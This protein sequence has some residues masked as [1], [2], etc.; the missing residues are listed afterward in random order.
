MSGSFLNVMESFLLGRSQFVTNFKC[1]VWYITYE[2]WCST[3]YRAWSLAFSGVCEWHIKNIKSSIARFADD[4]VLSYS[5]KCPEN[6]HSVLSSDL[7]TL[8]SWADLWSI[9]FNVYKVQFLTISSNVSHHPLL[10]LAN[11]LL[12]EVDSHKQLG[13]IFHRSSSWHTH[14]ISQGYH[15]TELS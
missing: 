9:I 1:Q 2:L 14:V 11:H 12:S 6:L 10:H 7:N 8:Q 15:K 13:R 5:S 4:T 3:R